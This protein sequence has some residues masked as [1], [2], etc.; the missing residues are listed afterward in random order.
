MDVRI[1]NGICPKGE[2]HLP[3]AKSEVI[4]AA[5]LFALS[6]EAPE[7]A[8]RGF[9]APFCDDVLHAL[10]AFSAPVPDAGESAALMR[11]LIPILL[12]KRGEARLFLSPRL[13]E[14]GIYELESCLGAVALRGANTLYLR[15]DMRRDE[16]TVDCSRS[17]QFFSGFVLALGG[18]SRECLVRARGMVSA[19]YV[20]LTLRMAREFGAR[21][22]E[23]GEEYRIFPAG[24]R[25]PE[26]LHVSFDRSAA[27]VFE[28]MNLLGGSVKLPEGGSEQADSAFLRLAGRD[29]ASVRDCPDLAPLLAVAACKK[30]GETL[31]RGT[32]R[33]RSKESDRE[34]GTVDMIRTLGG[35][36][37]VLEDAILINGRGGLSGGEYDPGNDHRMAFAAAAAAAICD[38]PVVIRRAE[39]VNKSFPAFFTELKKL[40]GAGEITEF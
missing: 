14:R 30:T 39:C 17:S 1:E 28:L 22:E 6:G 25:A 40:C 10:H 8:V 35:E 29:E 16:F 20:E 36:A 21:I 32:A 7:R 38:K 23:S 13:M 19:P 5:L 3:P 27:A 4:R 34:R 9:E 18:S 24:Y 15:A 2:A 12:E 26:A 11:M 37:R 31:I 33:L